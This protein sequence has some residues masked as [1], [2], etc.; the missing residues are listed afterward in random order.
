MRQSFGMANPGKPHQLSDSVREQ[1][2]AIVF[3]TNSFPFGGLDLTVLK[4]WARRAELAD[5]EVW[6]PE[7]VLWELTEHAAA[8]WE[9]HRVSLRRARKAMGRAGLEVPLES[10]YDSRETVMAAVESVVVALNPAVRILPVDPD[11]AREALKDQILLRQ[12]G[13]K[14][15]EVK[16]GAADSAWLRQVL[17]EADRNVDRFVIVGSD[18]DVEQ[19]FKA[20]GLQQ[21]HMVKLEHLD[22]ALFVLEEVPEAEMASSII[23]FLQDHIDAPESSEG[24]DAALVLGEIMNGDEIVGE[25]EFDQVQDVSLGRI[26]QILGLNDLT[27]NRLAGIVKAQVFFNVELEYT[28]I[29]ID[30]DGETVTHSRTFPKAIVRDL[31]A[32]TF[33]DNG[34]VIEARSETGQAHT[35]SGNSA[36]SDSWDAYA[37]LLEAMALIPGVGRDK[38]DDA[39]IGHGLTWDVG[40]WELTFTSEEGG[41]DPYWSATV[42]LSNGTTSTSA[43]FRC[44]WD[45][46]LT[47]YD[48]PDSLPAYVVCGEDDAAFF[49]PG[50]WS[51]PAWVISKIWPSPHRREPIGISRRSVIEE[52]RDISVPHEDGDPQL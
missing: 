5:L 37:E 28:G 4:K 52:L 33:D 22:A 1:L 34:M 40:G 15:Q 3:D 21:P 25:W 36:F 14:K 17:K 47:S 50:E 41:G 27:I 19:A 2:I 11:I 38:I 26:H 30:S 32:F 48:M 13:K 31:L 7:P 46:S 39:A 35:F 6:L 51:A 12:P 29:R 10:P 45:G 42:T 16:T 9:E 43:D 20:W 18:K 8:A 23:E 24:K 44:E 49:E